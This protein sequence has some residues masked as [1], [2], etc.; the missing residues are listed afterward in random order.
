M[1]LYNYFRLLKPEQRKKLVNIL[2]EKAKGLE[3]KAYN[4]HI[5]V[6]FKDDEILLFIPKNKMNIKIKMRD[7]K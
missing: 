1:K 5:D 2:L 3:V 7:F 4:E 6:E